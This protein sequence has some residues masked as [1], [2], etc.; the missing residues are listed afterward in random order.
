M[1]TKTI[2]GQIS[3]NKKLIDAIE[4]VHGWFIE[5]NADNIKLSADTGERLDDLIEFF[6]LFTKN[7]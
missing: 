2:H 1:H 5:W 6:N 7:I 3:E 4:S